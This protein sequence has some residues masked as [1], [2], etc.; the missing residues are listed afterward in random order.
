MTCGTLMEFCSDD[1]GIPPRLPPP[2]PILSYYF[3]DNKLNSSFYCEFCSNLEASLDPLQKELEG[4][5]G[6]LLSPATQ[7]LTVILFIVAAISAAVGSAVTLVWRKWFRC[8]DGG[9]VSNDK[10]KF[11][12]KNY[13]PKLVMVCFLLKN[14]HVIF[15][16]NQVFIKSIRHITF[17]QFRRHF[18][19]P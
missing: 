1:F 14:T 10:N 18:G 13:A 15:F 16:I 4:S 2:P 17:I 3:E 7:N 12:E 11:I 6:G 5:S 19:I 8:R 9:Y